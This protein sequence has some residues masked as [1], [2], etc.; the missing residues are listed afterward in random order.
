MKCIFWTNLVILVGCHGYWLTAPLSYSSELVLPPREKLYVKAYKLTWD[1]IKELGSLIFWLYML[2]QDKLLSWKYDKTVKKV[3]KY[4]NEQYANELICIFWCFN[5]L[6]N[7]RKNEPSTTKL[8]LLVNISM[9]WNVYFEQI[10]SF[11]V[12]AMV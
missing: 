8:C 6:V 7:T 9:S 2:A 12:V 10:W 4:A 11:G 5:K 1:I 3:M